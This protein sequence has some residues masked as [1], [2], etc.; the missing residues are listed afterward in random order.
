MIGDHDGNVLPLK[1]LAAHLRNA[2]LMAGEGTRS[3]TAESADGLGADDR[4]LPVQELAA[5]LHFIEFRVTILRRPALHHIADINVLA[6]DF[7]AFFL[8]RVFDHLGEQLPGTADER[9]T[10]RV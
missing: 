10:L 9:D 3:D 7:D 2:L 5:N 6:E 1:P 4:K 8:R